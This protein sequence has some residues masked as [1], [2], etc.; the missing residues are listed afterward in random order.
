MLDYNP[1]SIFLVA[2]AYLS[3]VL[4][5]VKTDKLKMVRSRFEGA[6]SVYN[7]IYFIIVTLESPE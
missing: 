3:N 2:K 6:I 1:T 7:I 5:F 4:L